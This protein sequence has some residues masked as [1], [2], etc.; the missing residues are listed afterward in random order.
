MAAARLA[1]ACREPACRLH[2]VREF[3]PPAGGLAL[4]PGGPLLVFAAVTLRIDMPGG[5]RLAALAGNQGAVETVGHPVA[6][7]IGDHR[8]PVRQSRVVVVGLPGRRVRD[9]LPMLAVVSQHVAVQ[10]VLLGVQR[11]AR[12]N[13]DRVVQVRVVST[14]SLDSGPSERTWM[15]WRASESAAANRCSRSCAGLS[16]PAAEADVAATFGAAGSPA[17]LAR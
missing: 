4:A 15:P 3:G 8:R 16:H 2:R 11:L 17:T 9:I 7:P 6:A 1:A 10:I 5:K 14:S 13:L 12:V